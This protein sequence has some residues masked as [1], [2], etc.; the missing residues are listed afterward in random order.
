ML[1]FSITHVGVYRN[2]ERHV[3]TA[4]CPWISFY[5]SGLRH[6]RTYLP[7]GRLLRED[8]PRTGPYLAIKPPG[9]KIDF[10]HGSKRENWVIMLKDFPVRYSDNMDCAEIDLGSWTGVPFFTELPKERVAGWQAEFKR[11]QG[12]LEE[13]TPLNVCKAK[14]GVMNILR[15]MIERRTDAIGESPEERLKQLIDRDAGFAS[16]ISK[17]G[18]SCNV[19]P[20]HLRLLFQR[21]YR[22]KPQAYRQQRRNAYVM[23]MIANSSLSIKEIASCAGFK[24]MS[25]FCAEFKRQFGMTPKEGV[26]HFRYLR[27]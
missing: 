1:D 20:D 17:L 4:L 9:M 10:E 2:A 21:R 25:H 8:G 13:P 22:I 23:E 14:L 5:V 19:S 18:E 3:Q 12:F 16:S 7:D 24:H 27:P 6:S 15:F 26:R 11:L